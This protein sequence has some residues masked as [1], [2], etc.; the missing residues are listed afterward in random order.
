MKHLHGYAAPAETEGAVI[1]WA[2]FYDLVT[3][4]VTFG[5]AKRLRNLTV[6]LSLLRPGESI[7]D[8]GCGTGGVT[9]PAKQR[10]GPEGKAVGIDPAPGMIAM[11]KQKAKSK[12]LDIDFRVGVIEALPFPDASFDA[13]TAS[14]MMHHLPKRLRAQGAAEIYRVLKPTG[15]LLVADLI[16]PKSFA[17]L[18]AMLIILLHHGWPF[19]GEDLRRLLTEAGFP[20]AVQLDQRFSAVGFVRATKA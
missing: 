8:L 1:R 3:N 14:L 19:D 12:G 11:A 7:L 18:G 6:E 13:V 17:G 16:R 20:D 4:V 9:I 2:P 5:Q 15:R 10:A